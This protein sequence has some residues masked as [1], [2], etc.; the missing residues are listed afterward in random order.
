MMAYH[1]TASLE[2]LK[3]RALALREIRDFFWERDVLEVDTPILGEAPVTDP[4]IEALTT[5]IKHFGAQTF[6]HQTSPEYYLKRLLAAYPISVYQ[7]GKV[8][9]DD[10]Y[11]RY[12]SPEFTMLEWYR[13]GFDDEALMDEMEALFTRLWQTFQGQAL[14]MLRLSYKEVFLRYLGLNPHQA[15]QAELQ[16]VVLEKL[17]PIQGLPDPDIDTCLQLLLSQV[18]EPLLAKIE[19]PVFIKHF[20]ASQAALAQLKTNEA[21]E[22]ISGRFEV[23]WQGVELANGYHE[24][25]DP[26]LQAERFQADV[27]SRKALCLPIVPIDQKLLQALEVGLPACAGVALGLDRLLMILTQAT[28]LEEVLTFFR[29]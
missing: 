7:L 4:H 8:F 27:A 21:G 12:H 6:Y 17:G 20:P 23:Y 13:L 28:A 25:M 26:V 1:P 22:A 15:S 2:R 9:R 19:G 5:R 14:P 16:A 10:E 29:F 24:L 3:L 11:G 18:I